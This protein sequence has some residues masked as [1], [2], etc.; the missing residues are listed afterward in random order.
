LGLFER[1]DEFDDD[2]LLEDLPKALGQI[3]PA[4]VPA[5]SAYLADRSHGFGARLTAAHSLAEVGL[6]H[7]ESRGKCVTALSDQLALQR[8]F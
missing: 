3:G 1:V 6:Q 7:P 4:A 5:L 8:L 2:W